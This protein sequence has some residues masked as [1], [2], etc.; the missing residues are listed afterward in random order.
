M[1]RGR[2]EKATKGGS[3]FECEGAKRATI[4]K[5]K[6]LGGAHPRA[7]RWAMI[8]QLKEKEKNSLHGPSYTSSFQRSTRASPSSSGFNSKIFKGCL[9][10]SPLTALGPIYLIYH[11]WVPLYTT[12]LVQVSHLIKTWTDR[13]RDPVRRG[14]TI[15]A[16][17][18]NTI[19]MLLPSGSTPPPITFL[20][21]RFFTVPVSIFPWFLL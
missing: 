19:L 7:R 18:P 20:L 6:S 14:C 16:S 17:T 2:I 4:N 21:F 13:A 3:I 9:V 10:C 15:T 11:S 8:G 1:T 5:E 12:L